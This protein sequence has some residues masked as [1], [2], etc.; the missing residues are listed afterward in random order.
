M[1]IF[2]KPRNT[3]NYV[4][5]NSDMCKVLHELGYYPVYRFKGEIYFTKTEEIVEVIKTWNLQTK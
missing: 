5:V 4:C 2:G 1:V 3:L